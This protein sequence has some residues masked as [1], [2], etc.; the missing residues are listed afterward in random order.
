[1][2]KG[3]ILF[4]AAR[5]ATFTGIYQGSRLLS[6]QGQLRLS[7][8]QANWCLIMILDSINADRCQTV[9]GSPDPMLLY[10]GVSALHIC[11]FQVTSMYRRNKS[12]VS[13]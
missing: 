5:L 9:F 8:A 6:T 1:M 4:S 11:S 10:P 7:D 13:A 3:L 12:P 2:I